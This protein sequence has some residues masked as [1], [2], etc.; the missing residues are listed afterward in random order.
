MARLRR[1]RPG[2]DGLIQIAIV[3]AVIALYEFVRMLMTPNW[4]LAL[5]NAHDVV[6]WERFVHINWERSI[7]Q[8]FLDLPDLVRA[9]N[10]FYFLGHFVLTGV[11]FVWLYHRSRS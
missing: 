2:R 9:M 1:L 11:F 10:A 3:L 7:Q 8:A 5:A 4:P 6:S